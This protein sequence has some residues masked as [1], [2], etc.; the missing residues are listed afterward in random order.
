MRGI[1]K[2]TQGLTPRRGY[3]PLG[4]IAAG[5]SRLDGVA[6]DE[7]KLRL[8]SR[9]CELQQY[10]RCC[11]KPWPPTHE[12][13]GGCRIAEC[14]CRQEFLGWKACPGVSHESFTF[15]FI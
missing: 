6:L 11:C 9:G 15:T 4:V 2:R 14:G 12:L 13:R 7:Q 3:L 5:Q 10:C 8:A 1:L